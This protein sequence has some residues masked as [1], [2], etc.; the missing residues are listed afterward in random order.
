VNILA[1]LGVIFVVLKLAGV[2]AW[3]WWLVLLPFY[4]G[5]AVVALLCLIGLG[6][7]GSYFGGAAIMDFFSRRRARRNNKHHWS[8]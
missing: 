3:S 6:T 4:F 5:I 2:I 8:N 7:I 1:T